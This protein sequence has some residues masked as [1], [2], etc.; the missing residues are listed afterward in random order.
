MGEDRRRILIHGPGGQ[1]TRL[2]LDF[3]GRHPGEYHATLI[4]PSLDEDRAFSGGL[5]G[6]EVLEYAPVLRWP[7]R[8]GPLPRIAYR[9]ARR[10][11]RRAVRHGGPFDLLIIQGLYGQAWNS[12]VFDISNA[13]R[14][15]VYLWNRS[16][17]RKAA[18]GSD[19]QFS[20]SVRSMLE[21]ADLILA[22]WETTVTDFLEHYPEF[23]GKTAC[24]PWG[25][26]PETFAEGPAPLTHAAAA[27][28][29]GIGPEDGLVF[30]PRSIQRNNRHDV[31]LGAASLLPRLIGPERASRVWF[32]LL[33]GSCMDE[34]VRSVLDLERRLGI[35]T[36]RLSRGRFLPREDLL[37]LYDRARVLVNLADDDQMA[38]CIIEGFAR[39][40][41]VV[42]S[43]IEPYRLLERRGFK[44]FY[45][46][47][48]PGDAARVIVEALDWSA[49]PGAAETLEGNRDLAERLYSADASFS[50]II[51][52][53]TR[54]DAGPGSPIP[55]GGGVG[56]RCP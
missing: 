41:A 10:R 34:H 32:L 46:S 36:L 21:R 11:A 18:G 42:L 50:R 22:T 9:L 23:A 28:L 7:A 6:V 43:D 40:C 27:L 45:C 14:R 5:P 31:L 37:P 30:W 24:L 25:L 4:C 19:P 12:C 3:F 55:P 48:T 49:S 16:S 17:H 20:A 53:C 47:N 33:G 15:V 26:G 35:R 51:D 8:V 56:V 2:W 39:R 1:N 29:E 44:V 13:A 38:A 54:R 52:F